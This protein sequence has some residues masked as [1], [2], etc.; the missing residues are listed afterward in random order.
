VYP[1]TRPLTGWSETPPSEERRL[2]RILVT[3]GR[4]AAGVPGT[5]D[6]A[7]TAPRRWPARE[8]GLGE[9]RGGLGVGRIVARG[10]FPNT[11]ERVTLSPLLGD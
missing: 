9:G 4:P 5:F 3:G 8:S 11:I 10:L 2:R 6:A 1:N 7:A